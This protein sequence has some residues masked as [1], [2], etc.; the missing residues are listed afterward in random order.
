ARRRV[1]AAGAGPGPPRGTR[2]ERQ[3][4]RSAP[5]YAENCVGQ[6]A[7]VGRGP[8]EFTSAGR[9][10]ACRPDET[11]LERRSV[12]PIGVLAIRVAAAF[13]GLAP[14]RGDA[15]E[16]QHALAVGSPGPTRARVLAF[17]PLRTGAE[18]AQDG[19]GDVVAALLAPRIE[20]RDLE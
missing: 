5:R 12:K 6:S 16:A 14:V 9:G 7:R 20:T 17:E 18:R 15:H 2:E 10:G 19:V 13:P 8:A 1:P 11:R 3:T 4:V